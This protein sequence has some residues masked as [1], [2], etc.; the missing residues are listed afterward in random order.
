MRFQA[1]RNI[2][3]VKALNRNKSTF[4]AVQGE[5]L[6][7]PDSEQWR[8]LTRSHRRPTWRA[9]D[10]I[11]NF[12]EVAQLALASLGMRSSFLPRQA[13]LHFFSLNDTVIFFLFLQSFSAGTSVT[14]AKQ[15]SS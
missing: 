3:F 10:Q 4:L 11:K 2:D 8:K 9:G 14:R 6:S 13:T 5:A 12:N 15:N 1:L 7:L